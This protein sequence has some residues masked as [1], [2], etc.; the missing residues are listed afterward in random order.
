MYDKSSKV[1]NFWWKI[2]FHTE[3]VQSVEKNYTF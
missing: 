2:L 3:K 1:V